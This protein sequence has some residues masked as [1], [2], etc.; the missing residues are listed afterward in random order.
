MSV[1]ILRLGHRIRRDKRISTHCA[2]VARALGAEG[3][4]Y[5]GEK[6]DAMEDSVKKVV[7]NWGGRF[8]VKHEKKWETVLSKWKGKSA[9]LTV[10]GMPYEKEIPKIRKAKDILL[11]VGGE[12]VPIDVYKRMDWNLS[13]TSQPHSEVASIA[14]FLDRYFRG[15]TPTFRGKLKV[16]PQERGK[17]IIKA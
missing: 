7:K 17:K 5:T 8:K 2:L 11:V 3:L 4:I 13:V 16:V 15:K 6:D 14:L 10:Y 9:Q 1:W 12:K